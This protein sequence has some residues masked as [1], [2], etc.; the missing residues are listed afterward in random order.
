M[1]HLI[2]RIKKQFLDEP[3]KRN[4][5]GVNKQHILTN[6]NDQWR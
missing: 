3:K 6:D 1:L 5:L 4:R 2:K